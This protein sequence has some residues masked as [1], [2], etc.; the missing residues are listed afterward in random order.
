MVLPVLRGDRAPRNQTEDAAHERPD[1]SAKG[2]AHDRSASRTNDSLRRIR[3]SRYPPNDHVGAALRAVEKTLR[4]RVD[5]LRE[6]VVIV[7]YRPRALGVHALVLGAGLLLRHPVKVTPVRSVVDVSTGPPRAR[8]LPIV[9]P[10][11]QF[12]AVGCQRVA[13]A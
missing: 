2:P 12:D 6:Q 5:V 1:G 4:V 10:A 8:R 3:R 7:S 9:S 13:V 11:L